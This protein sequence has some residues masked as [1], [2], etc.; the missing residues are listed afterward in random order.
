MSDRTTLEA[1]R[2]LVGAI[3][4]VLVVEDEDKMRSSL[5]EGLAMEG[6]TI[7][8]AAN[9]HQAA[10]MMERDAF[11]LVVLDWRMPGPDGLVLLRNLR[12]KEIHT[13]V[14]MLSACDAVHDRVTALDAGADDYLSK[15]FAFAELVARS[16]ALLR[17]PLSNPGPLLRC[18]DLQLDVRKRTVTHRGRYI[19][20]SPREVDVLEYMIRSKGQI[21]TREMLEREV[22]RQSRQ[23]ASL[24]NLIDVQMMRLRRKLEGV[25]G[26]NLIETLR[27]VGYRLGTDAS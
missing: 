18:G 7:A 17:R 12:A 25:A 20:L 23:W 2:P 14:L 3:P 27:G 4:R 13:P 22:W 9:G 19:I 6:W 26:E 11:D 10:E 15:P 8:T 16:R 24:N 1:A 5:A 21:V